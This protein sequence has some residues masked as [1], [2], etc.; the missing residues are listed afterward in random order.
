MA[1]VL[2]VF[3][4]EIEILREKL[5]LYETHAGS[6][7]GALEKRVNDPE[8]ELDEARIEAHECRIEVSRATV[9]FDQLKATMAEAGLP[10]HLHYDAPTESLD[11][12]IESLTYPFS[13]L[14]RAYFHCADFSDRLVY[15]KKC[16]FH[17]LPDLPPYV[18]QQGSDPFAFV[19]SLIKYSSAIVKRHNKAEDQLEKLSQF[20]TCR[21]QE[22]NQRVERA[23]IHSDD[24]KIQLD[25]IRAISKNMYQ[26]IWFGTVDFEK[27]GTTVETLRTVDKFLPRMVE[28]LKFLQGNSGRVYQNPSNNPG[29][30]SDS[31]PAS[32]RVNPSP[33]QNT[34]VTFNQEGKLA[35]AQMLASQ[36]AVKY[37]KMFPQADKTVTPTPD[38]KSWQ[39]GL[40]EQPLKGE[41]DISLDGLVRILEESGAFLGADL[42]EQ[43]IKDNS[44]DQEHEAAGGDEEEERYHSAPSTP[45]LSDSKPISQT[46][47]QTSTTLQEIDGAVEAISKTVRQLKIEAS[48]HKVLPT[49]P[50]LYHRPHLSDLQVIPVRRSTPR[51]TNQP[52]TSQ[53]ASNPPHPAS[54][55]S[56]PT[57]QSENKLEMLGGLQSPPAPI[58]SSAVPSSQPSYSFASSRGY[59]WPGWPA[60]RDSGYQDS[61][62][63]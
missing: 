41:G 51:T 49:A 29:T 63:K 33:Q 9:S 55:G 19:E 62:S 53:P 26:T 3:R 24:L 8:K 39:D 40:M 22:L 36:A 32:N 5:S 25:Q 14:L 23:T 37:N 12:R 28:K 44:E 52:E 21:V 56:K 54:S 57:P 45:A 13:V 11:R 7:D 34:S 17:A 6:L 16:A 47:T 27:C 48:G 35:A 2:Q 10:Q 4:L 60:Q 43:E 31:D 59:R 30:Q 15:L 46:S 38:L 61:F 50:L 20:Y 42:G 1:A 18:T 58:P